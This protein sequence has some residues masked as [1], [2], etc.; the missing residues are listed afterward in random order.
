MG[1]ALY[2]TNVLIDLYKQGVRELKGYTTILNVV[3]FP[4]ILKV[5]KLKVIYPSI[6]DYDL[7]VVI[8]KDLYKAGKPVPTIDILV[9][10]MAINRRLVL[11]TKNKHF[12][13]IKEVMKDMLLK[14]I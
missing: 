8:S 9:A 14:I 11:T 7:A 2:D 1:K 10:A 13:Y 12:Q 6:N 4:K 5:K 3:E